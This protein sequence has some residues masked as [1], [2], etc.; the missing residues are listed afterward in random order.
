MK[1]KRRRVSTSH[2]LVNASLAISL[3]LTAAAC[4]GQE[5]ADD[6]DDAGAARV[7]SA[8]SADAAPSLP[9]VWSTRALE[10]AVSAMA[11]SKGSAPVLAVAFE[12]GGLQ[13]FNF[14]AERITQIAPYS[15]RSLGSG[16]RTSVSG[17]P[18]ILFPGVTSDGSIEA[19]LLG[20]GADTIFNAELPIDADSPVQG[21]CAANRSGDADTLLS[22]AYWTEEA[23]KTLIRGR[24]RVESEAFVWSSEEQTEY[25]EPI[26]ACHI[27]DDETYVHT[28]KETVATWIERDS[29]TYKVVPQD[30][31]LEFTRDT[32]ETKR[33]AIRDGLSVAAPDNPTAIAASGRPLGGGYPGGVVIVAGKLGPGEYQAVFVDTSELT[34][35]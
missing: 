25:G 10:G 13:F 22:L 11:V 9:A 21:I 23:P 35:P 32:A 31:D 16:V 14:D 5:Q 34:A 24:V 27:A 3:L 15:V 26:S 19:F 20:D 28:G 6:G 12:D 18:L 4:G 30:D 33:Y 1:F 29:A 7:E 8:P 2:R 17:T